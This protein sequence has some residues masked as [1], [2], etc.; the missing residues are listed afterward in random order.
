MLPPTKNTSPPL[1]QITAAPPPVLSPSATP[2]T[3]CTVTWLDVAYSTG[4]G[5]GRVVVGSPRALMSAASAGERPGCSSRQ[6]S[7]SVALTPS[8][9][10]R[11]AFDSP[12]ISCG[13]VIWLGSVVLPDGGATLPYSSRIAGPIV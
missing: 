8:E 1:I 12:M 6:F 13:S 10:T 4:T 7:H 11:G 9:V 2:W 5:I 3:P